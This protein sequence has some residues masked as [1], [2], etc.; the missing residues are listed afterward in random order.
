MHAEKHLEYNEKHR[1]SGVHMC[2]ESSDKTLNEHDQPILNIIP[3]CAAVEH[4]KAMIH[5]P[6]KLQQLG[7]A[8]LRQQTADGV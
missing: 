5:V 7:A 1:V 6:H 8:V 3:T 4:M 2:F